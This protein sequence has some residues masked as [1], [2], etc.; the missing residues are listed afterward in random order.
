MLLTKLFSFFR[1]LRPFLKKIS[2]TFPNITILDI[3]RELF[4]KT[5]ELYE[6]KL[7]PSFVFISGDMIVSKVNSRPVTEN[8]Y[9]FPYCHRNYFKRQRSVYPNLSPLVGPTISPRKE[10]LQICKLDDRHSN[11]PISLASDFCTKGH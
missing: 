9:N 6:I 5:A 2:E 1:E 3:D 10:N 7:A 11:I 4:P 8:H